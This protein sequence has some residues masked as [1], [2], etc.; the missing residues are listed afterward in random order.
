MGSSYKGSWFNYQNTYHNALL[1]ADK[2]RETNIDMD[3]WNN[4]NKSALSLQATM[5]I[6]ALI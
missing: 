1:W 4:E 2:A 6:V 3:S 5:L